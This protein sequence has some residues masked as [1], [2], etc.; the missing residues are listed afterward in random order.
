[1]A[2]QL[3]EEQALQRKRLTDKAVS[4]AVQGRWEE[5]K[6]LNREIIK[7]FPGDVEAYN[8]LGKALTELGEFAQAKK[9]YLKALEIAPGNPIAKKNI[10]RLDTLPEF[11]GTPGGKMG[12]IGPGLFVA[13][14]TKSGIVNLHNLTQDGILARV[15]QGD[16]VQLAVEGQRLIVNER[17]GEYLGEVEPRHSSR[18]GKLI[19][20]G[21]KYAAAILS[22]KPGEAQVIIKE[23]YQHPEQVGI[24]SFPVRVGDSSRRHIR[25]GRLNSI[26]T[27]SKETVGATEPLE[28][29]VED[30][31]EDLPDGF[32]ILED[33]EG[34]REIET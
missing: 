4:L 15:T 7:G 20:G 23:V 12:G 2:Y 14:S 21:N 22:V 30:S 5:A 32:S 33:L 10:A 13:E 29:D 17:N 19:K 34:R 31:E 25:E 11:G 6:K 3:E 9:A 1:M 24:P 8:R 18:L 26:I 28:E 16:Q 27:R